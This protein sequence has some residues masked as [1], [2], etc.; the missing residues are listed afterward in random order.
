MATIKHIGENTACAAAFAATMAASLLLAQLA[1]TAVMT[2]G[3][4]MMY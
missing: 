1:A 4:L 2:L 3:Q